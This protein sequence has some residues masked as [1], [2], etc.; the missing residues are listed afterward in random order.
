MGS[1][2]ADFGANLDDKEKAIVHEMFGLL[3]HRMEADLLTKEI[4]VVLALP[5]QI[6]SE[7]SSNGTMGLV[8]AF[9]CKTQN[10]TQRENAVILAEFLC[11]A[12]G[13]RHVCYD[14]RRL[15]RAA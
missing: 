2:L 4:E 12:K 7:I 13:H 10:E 11:T 15:K 3:V 14:C 6:G 9:A 5:G 8:R 1:Q